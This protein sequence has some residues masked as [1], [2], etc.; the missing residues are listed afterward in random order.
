M[1]NTWWRD[2]DELAKEQ[3]DL[4]EV[5]AEHSLLIKGPPGSGKTN[6]LLLRA[7]QLY[8]GDYPNLYVVV[9]G[10]LL[11]NFIQ[12]G[13]AQYK[14]PPEKV[15]THTS[16]FKMILR[17]EG[18]DFDDRDMTLEVARK[19]RADILED[20]IKKG[21]V[22]AQF[23]ALLLDE[24]QDYTPQEIRLL[25]Q[26]ATILVA[27]ADSRQRIYDIEDCSAVLSSCV[28]TEHQLTYHFRNGRDICRVAD[29]IYKGS[30]QYAPMLPHSNYPEADYPSKAVPKD[31]LSL[32]DQIIAMI[33]QIRDQRFAYPD[34]LIG[35][36][37][38][39]NQELDV[40]EAGLIQAGLGNYITRANAVN[41]FDPSRPIWLS[42]LTAAKGLEFRA[43]HI[44]GLEHLSKM[45][46]VQKRL[47]FTGVTRAKTALTCYWHNSVPGYFES[48]CRPVVETP[49]VVTKKNIFGN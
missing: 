21:Q 2:E 30:P 16:L 46:S 15:V 26:L 36:L 25:S 20:L 1:S 13:G 38:P 18:A 33:T 40:I 44:A 14:F 35:V 49:K 34:D 32:Q 42:T 43:A 41:R 19:Q 28:R 8:L 11:K 24:A 17:L 39:R 4:L 47:I 37:A 5:P 27:T 10:A 29:G 45:G 6:L 7:N 9:F 31:G 23:D 48:A 22:G 3:S 12:I